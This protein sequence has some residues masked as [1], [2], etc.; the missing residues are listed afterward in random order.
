MT[1]H[2]DLD[3]VV[4]VGAARSGT[5]AIRDALALATGVPAIPYD[6]SYV[7]RCGNDSI[8]HDRQTAA[9]VRP[10]TRRMVRDFL[11]R[12]ADDGGRVIEKTVGSSLRVGYVHEILPDATFVHLV[13]NGVDVAESTRRQWLAPADYG[14]LKEKFHHFPPRL[15]A[16]YGRRHALSLLRR[17][18]AGDS[19]VA[20]WGP[21]Y[22]GIDSDV[23]SIE[24]LAVC[25]RQ[26][27]HAVTLSRA[28][29]AATGIRHV[30]LRYEEVVARPEEQLARVVEA[31][32]WDVNEVA[33]R[34]GAEILQTGHG[35]G[36]ELLTA[37]ELCTLEEEIGDLLEELGYPRP[38]QLGARNHA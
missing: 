35:R 26:W 13:R 10:R 17:R 6:V 5:K 25:A 33:L 8:P 24:L 28:D 29:F 12:Y 27:M 9:D 7:W 4:L 16:T 14:Y 20:S 32:G 22:P 30:E 1:A 21:R 38:T 3:P 19:R 11:A 15:L 36:A 37:P 34:R 23:R 2:A 31:A 18:L